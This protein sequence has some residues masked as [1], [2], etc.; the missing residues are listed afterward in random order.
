MNKNVFSNSEPVWNGG[1]ECFVGDWRRRATITNEVN[2]KKNPP[3]LVEKRG[4]Q[5]VKLATE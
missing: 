1:R 2:E 4:R 5:S 3:S